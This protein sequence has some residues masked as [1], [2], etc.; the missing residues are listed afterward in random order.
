M[1]PVDLSQ[2]K[3]IDFKVLR[4]TGMSMNLKMELSSK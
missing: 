3:K 1:M 2:G 4:N